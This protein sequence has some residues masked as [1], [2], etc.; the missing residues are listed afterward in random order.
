M[1]IVILEPYFTGSHT[2][3]A[4]GFKKYSKHNITILSLNG[5]FWKWRMHGGAVSL[6]KKFME[7]ELKP[8]LFLATDMLD[9]TTFLSLTRSRTAHIPIAIYFHENQLCYPWSPDDR[10]RAHKRD[11]HYGFIN[12]ASAL[13]AD[14]VFF[15][16]SFHM[17]S[18]LSE[19][20][21]F[22]NHFPDH[23]EL[24]SIE[25]IAEK[26]RV[27]HLGL[28]L[29]R[30]DS[31]E[32][33]QKNAGNKNS[34]PLVLWNHRWEYD[35]N[36]DDF[37]RML[38]KLNEQKVDFQVAILGENFS[39]KPKEFGEARQVLGEKVVQYGYAEN[40]KSYADWLWRADILPVTSNQDFF[41]ASI[42]EAV[43]SGCYPLLPERLTY[44]ELFPI[45][46]FQE[47]YYVDFEDLVIKMASVIQNINKI[48]THKL[49]KKR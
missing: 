34:V 31:L 16:S 32:S 48:N 15:N 18:L 29:S 1:N 7:S 2:A 36:P 12:F 40:F 4:E 13:A 10:D 47:H 21:K 44:P 28:D 35:K 14:A 26:S 43:Y 6:A 23:K 25:K 17:T 24:E 3:W 8:D 45:T 37:F 49:K 30:F 42:V 20:K 38:L 33:V 11:K 19:L 22:L 27:L 41:G 9:V 39:R 46:E 5:Q